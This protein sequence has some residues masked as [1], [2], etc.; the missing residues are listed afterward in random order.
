MSD[1]CIVSSIISCILAKKNNP[2][3][4]QFD[5]LV[6][7]HIYCIEN[8]VCNNFRGQTYLSFITKEGEGGLGSNDAV[9]TLHKGEGI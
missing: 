5:P 4:V 7:E 9:A 3:V 1:M 2:Y 8:L 6:P